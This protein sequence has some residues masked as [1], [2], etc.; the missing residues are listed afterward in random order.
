MKGDSFLQKS[1]ELKA[2]YDNIDGLT[3]GN[4][5]IYNGFR[6]GSVKGID[7]DK[8]TGKIGVNFSLEQGIEV[9][10]NSVAV[11]TS[12]DLLGS[13]VIRIDRGDATQIA[14]SGHPLKGEVDKDLSTRVIE[15][16]LPLKD[17]LEDLLGQTARFMGWLNN[18]MDD[19]AG[20]KVESILDDF[21]TTS[22]NFARTS[23]R[24]DTLLGS[25]QST[26]YHANKIVRNINNQNETI[27]RIMG[28]AAT[29]S[30]SIAATATNVK[31]M[32]EQTSDVI[33]DLEGILKKIDQGEGSLGALM[34][35][36]SLYDNLNTTIARVDTLVKQF[37]V[38]PTVKLEHSVNLFNTK[39][40]RIERRQRKEARKD[41]RS[42]SVVSPEDASFDE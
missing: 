29:F 9:P 24:I 41:A 6:V 27:N 5:V 25:F 4:P 36:R 23:H 31:E 20:N 16:I 33:A 40:K 42:R 14:K 15:E 12:A 38:D 26:A 2:Y 34:T 8:K 17:K 21:A 32:V 39:E 3:V 19:N 1:F 37:T 7:I 10:V 18:T 13:K 22:R 11:I 30:D 35:D 28:N